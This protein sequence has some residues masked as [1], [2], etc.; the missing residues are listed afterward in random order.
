MGRSYGVPRSAKGESR[1]L[2]IFTIKS[3]VTSLMGAGVGFI[4]Y[5]VFSVMGLKTVGMIVMAIMA[6]IGYGIGTFSIPDSPIV[7]NLRKAGGEQISDIL[8]R[9]LT[10]KNRK[11]IYVYREVEKK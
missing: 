3:T 6:F 8:V 5:T 4:L 9:T 10:F 7:G 2:Y 11:K 1:F